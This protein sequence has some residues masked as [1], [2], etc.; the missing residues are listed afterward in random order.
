[1][2]HRL[3]AFVPNANGHAYPYTLPLLWRW[4]LNLDLNRIERNIIYL[5]VPKNNSFDSIICDYFYRS[6]STIPPL[7]VQVNSIR[8]ISIHI[9]ESKIHISYS[10]NQDSTLFFYY[11]YMSPL[12]TLVHIVAKS[13]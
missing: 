12:P 5:I 4:K 2:S 7:R 6:P 11:F 3:A 1:M 9:T 10:R 8:S 13:R